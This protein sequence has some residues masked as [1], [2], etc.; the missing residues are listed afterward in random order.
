[1]EV[2]APKFPD[3]VVS[4]SGQDGNAGAIMGRVSRALTGAGAGRDDVAQFRAECMSGDYYNLLRTV[5]EW[6]E[7]E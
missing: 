2:K 5:M 6:V 1:M 4:L 7:V 3:V